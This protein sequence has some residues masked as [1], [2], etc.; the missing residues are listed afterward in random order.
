MKLFKKQFSMSVPA[1]TQFLCLK[2]QYHEGKAI[3][4]LK[5]SIMIATLAAAFDARFLNFGTF[6]CDF[7]IFSNLFQAAANQSPG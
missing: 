4:C 6:E 2:N 7:G 1:L 3:N 5:Y